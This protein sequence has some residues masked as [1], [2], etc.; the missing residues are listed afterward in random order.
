M[1]PHPIVFI[2]Q[3]IQY[4]FVTKK[5][6]LLKIIF[7]MIDIKTIIKWNAIISPYKTVINCD[8]WYHF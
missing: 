7:F 1:M 4:Y 3:I 2:T 5:N 6:G 8:V